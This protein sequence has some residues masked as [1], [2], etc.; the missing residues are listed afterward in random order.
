[1]AI[2]DWSTTAADNDDADASI[3]WAEGQAPSTVNG[4]ARAMMAAL[5]TWYNT[6][7]GSGGSAEIGYIQA[8]SGESHTVQAWLRLQKYVL[9]WIPSNLWAGILAGT[10]TTDLRTYIQEAMDD[11]GAAGGGSI[12][13]TP[14]L[15][16]VKSGTTDGITVSLTP[17][18]DNLNLHLQQGAVVRVTI[19]STLLGIGGFFKAAGGV[20]NYDDYIV[21]ESANHGGAFTLY[22]ISAASK[23]AD[24]VTLSTAS[25]HSNF[26]VGDWILIRTGQTRTVGTAEPIGEFNK[27]RAINTGTGELSL[28]YPLKND[29]DSENYPVGHASAGNPVPFGIINCTSPTNV[30]L[31]NFSITGQGRLENTSVATTRPLINGSQTIN[32]VI[33]GPELVSYNHVFSDSSHL[34]RTVNC[35]IHLLGSGTYWGYAQATCHHDWLLDDCIISSRGQAQIHLHEGCSGK[36]GGGVTI[37][38]ADPS[39]ATTTENIISI[40]SRSHDIAIGDIKIFGFGKDASSP[41]IYADDT[42]TRI[43]VGSATIVGPANASA[44]AVNIVGSD[45]A[46]GAINTDTGCTIVQDADNTIQGGLTK[47]I[48]AQELAS[49]SGS[50][51][52]TFTATNRHYAW[53]LDATSDEAVAWEGRV[54]VE[55][56]QFRVR[57]WYSNHTADSGDIRWQIFRRVR[58]AGDSLATGTDGNNSFTETAPAQDTLKI[59]T[60]PSQSWTVTDPEFAQIIVFRDAD[61]AADTKAGDIALIGIELIRTF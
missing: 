52:L 16:N 56:R 45:C 5:K 31:H 2:E 23:Y 59:S 28:E 32:R 22:A 6:L 12:I 36:I 49:F 44:N 46:V 55:W 53:L 19:D 51:S 33:D 9:G 10:D 26:S 3:N 27:I 54:P 15:Y 1:M 8:G 7:T 37:I 35:R 18:Y 4:S 57:L 29:Y 34:G 14:G 13:F 60:I 24:S 61:N 30:L 41:A 38:S 11:V 39:T 17:L 47:Y 25:E 20:T 58:G 48:S 50:P 40:R 42:C 43:T 21:F